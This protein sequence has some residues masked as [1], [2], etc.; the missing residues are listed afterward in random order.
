MKDAKGN[1]FVIEK[2]RA[3]PPKKGPDFSPI[4]I[5]EIGDSFYFETLAL[6][7]KLYDKYK[8]Y[9]L[10]SGHNFKIVREGEGCRLFRIG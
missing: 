1:D 10:I 3:L 2:N 5:M 8:K 7:A 6:R 4:D 9:E